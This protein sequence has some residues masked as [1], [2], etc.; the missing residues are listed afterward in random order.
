[1]GVVVSRVAKCISAIALAVVTG[2]AGSARAESLLLSMEETSVIDGQQFLSGDLLSVDETPGSATLF[3]SDTLFVEPENVDAAAHQPDGSI[4]FSTAAQSQIGAAFFEDGDLIA[5]DPTTG[6][7]TL[8]L[9]DDTEFF[10]DVD[11]DGVHVLE[12]GHILFSVRD[13]ATLFPQL[14]GEAFYRDGD[15]IE[16]DPDAGTTSLYLSEAI[17]TWNVDENGDQVPDFANPDI[18]GLSMLPSGHLLLSIRSAA[19]IDEE[20]YS[21]GEI[22]EYDRET[23]VSSLYLSLFERSGTNFDVGAVSVY[24]PE[25]GRA[26]LLGSALAL[27]GI[28]KRRARPGR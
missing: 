5:Y 27:V 4:I 15:V 25:P 17:F 18:D 1:M 16:Y 21:D 10:A 6:A 2:S 13:D 19:K 24:L 26:L 23:G 9:D 3:L 8:W 11:I 20:V 22:I 7:A 12:N 14:P 28:P